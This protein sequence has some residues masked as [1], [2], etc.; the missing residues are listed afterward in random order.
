MK[1]SNLICRIALLQHLIESFTDPNTNHLIYTRC[2]LSRGRNQFPTIEVS[3]RLLKKMKA[4]QVS[5]R[6]LSV[7]KS[8]LSIAYGMASFNRPAV[9]KLS[10]Y[11]FNTNAKWLH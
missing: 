8:Y 3:P 1:I 2:V 7:N 10:R 6:L 11:K 4:H 5:G 9:N